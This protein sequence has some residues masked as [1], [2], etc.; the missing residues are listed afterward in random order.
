MD[1]GAVGNSGWG[2]GDDLRMREY[3]VREYTIRPEAGGWSVSLGS[4][5]FAKLVEGRGEAHA[6]WE[7]LG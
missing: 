5:G 7:V 4:R 3:K 2:Q 1:L 6:E